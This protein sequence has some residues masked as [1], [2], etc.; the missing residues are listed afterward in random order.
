M[1]VPQE[2]VD[3]DHNRRREDRDTGEDADDGDYGSAEAS[4]RVDSAGCEVRDRWAR[5]CVGVL[6]AQAVEVLEGQV[7]SCTEATAA[8][9]VDTTSSGAQLVR[10]SDNS[11]A[12]CV[13]FGG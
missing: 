7:A 11:L 9:N 2:L 13:V 5:C 3:V 6:L 10:A 4:G 12:R 8:S 1:F